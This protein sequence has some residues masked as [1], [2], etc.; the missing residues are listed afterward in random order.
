MILSSSVSY[1]GPFHFQFK[2]YLPRTL[3]L[4]A[5]LFRVLS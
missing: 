3:A 2:K 5:H 1:T 4:T